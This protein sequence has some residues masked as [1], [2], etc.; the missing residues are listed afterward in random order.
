[1]GQRFGILVGLVVLLG[2]GIYLGASLGTRSQGPGSGEERSG[3]SIAEGRVRVEVLNAGGVSGVAWE[4]TRVLRDRGFD[5]VSYGNAETYSGDSSVVMDR[6]GEVETARRVAEALGISAVR[7][8]RDS[9]L[10]VDVTVRLGPEW[11]GPSATTQ[12]G[13][14][15]EA[16]LDL[17]RLLSGGERSASDNS[18]RP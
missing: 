9:T 3:L 15:Q 14:G 17:R 18:T 13:G 11:R 6:V 10:L 16:R 12:G 2:L 7:S 5:V 8:E 4:A 1:M